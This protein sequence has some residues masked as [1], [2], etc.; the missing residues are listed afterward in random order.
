MIDLKKLEEK[1]ILT[2]VCSGNEEET[3]ASLQE[4]AALV[5]TAGAKTVGILVQNR[6]EL[7]S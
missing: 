1:V 5:S 7:R 3:A 2:A 4:L 6:E